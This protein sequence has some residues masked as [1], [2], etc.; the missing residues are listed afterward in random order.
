MCVEAVPGLT[1]LAGTAFAADGSPVEDDEVADL[2]TGHAFADLGHVS[3]GFVAEQERIVI[4]DAALAV[5]EVR[6]ADAARL[7]IDDDFARTRIGD[8]D[9]SEFD[10]GSLA[11]GDDALDSLWHCVSFVSSM[12]GMPG[13]SHP[14]LTEC[15]PRQGAHSPTLTKPTAVDQRRSACET[16]GSVCDRPGGPSTVGIRACPDDEGGP[17]RR[18]S[19]PPR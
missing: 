4:A 17:L 10:W 15:T 8:D 12:T 19:G 5:V 7:H 9:V 16:K 6:V 11:A 13:C 18:C 3:G 1:A 2:D 14:G